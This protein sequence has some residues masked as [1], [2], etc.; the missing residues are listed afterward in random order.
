MTAYRIHP[1]EWGMPPAWASA[2]G[3]DRYGP[4]L[5][6]EVAGITQ[7]LRWIPQGCFQMG[8]PQDEPG[9][10]AAEG[11]PQEVTF[12]HG[13]FLAESPCTQALWQA[14]LGHN[15]SRFKSPGRPVEQVS[16]EDCQRFLVRL[17]GLVPG[18]N[19]R[20]PT[21]SQWEYACR[22]G[23]ATYGASL[24]ILGE[25]NAPAL[26]PIAWYG[27]NCGRGFELVDGEDISDWKERQYEDPIGGTHAVGQK[28]PNRWGLYDMLGNVFEWCAAEGT[29]SAS[30]AESAVA[31]GSENS[32]ERP[33]RGGSWFHPARFVRAAYRL[34][35]GSEVRN[36]YL[37]FRFARDHDW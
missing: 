28:V 17:N 34:R 3:F 26:D 13:F 15:P 16:W 31:G 14:V 5:A 8:A 30:A 24:E 27:G 32:L 20:L 18:L 35:T 7:W 33:C 12:R 2:W 21:E 36:D 25:R 37:G 9:R 29:T 1:L 11:P 19:V 22:A 10:S 6:F 23:T 4:F